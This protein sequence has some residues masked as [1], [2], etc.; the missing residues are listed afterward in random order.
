MFR[1]KLRYK[2]VHLCIFKLTEINTTQVLKNLHA[3]F[4]QA[5]R[6]SEMDMLYTCHA[7]Y[8]KEFYF[9][10]IDTIETM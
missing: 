9:T 5:Y 3:I 6:N 7:L 2:N 4:K 10:F 1:N 8:C